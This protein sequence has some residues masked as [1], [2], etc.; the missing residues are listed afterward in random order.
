MV[1]TQGYVDAVFG[2]SRGDEAK[3]RFAEEL[4]REGEYQIVARF[5]GA[6]NAGHTATL[7]GVEVNT[8]QI[9][10]GI[11]VPTVRNLITKSS[12]VNPV[13]LGNEIDEL[14]GKGVQVNPDN[15]GVS[16]TAHLILPHHIIF[17]RLREEGV[18]RQGSTAKGISFVGAD[19]YERIGARV[20]DL[21]DDG[22]DLEAAVIAGILRANEALRK[23]GKPELDPEQEWLEWYR[24]AKWIRPYVVDTTAEITDALGLGGNIL[25]EGAQSFGLDIEHGTYPSVTSSH[26]TIG[27][28]LN[29]FGVGANVVRN[30]FGVAKLFKSSVGAPLDAFPTV[31][32][33]K[34]LAD[35][36]R[37]KEGAIDTERG[38]S[39]GRLRDVGWF[40][41]PEIRRAMRVNRGNGAQELLLS[42]LDC[43]PRA[44]RSILI[45]TT[46]SYRGEIVAESPADSMKKL[47]E[48]TPDYV[49]LPTWEGDIS[50][51]RDFKDLPK[52]AQR[53]VETIEEAVE[54]PVTRIGVGPYHGQLI[55][56]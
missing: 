13:S 22:G 7:K 31:I 55:K 9:P 30:T 6:D 46:Y 37:G 41:I 12:Y 43:A 27:G 38:K 19:K 47:R 5:N 50:G 33:D 36:I 11:L 52:E 34:A 3:G 18:G 24:K 49:E 28:V 25:A 15:L 16:D 48:C 14:K 42:K 21:V 23:A 45:A 39:T 26:T 2:L 40:D 4:A 20:E 10:M 53:I 29:S 54:V 44:G 32:H 8:H 17:D 1:E 56:R 35:S 51:I